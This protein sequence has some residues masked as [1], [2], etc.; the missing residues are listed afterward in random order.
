[1]EVEF[2]CRLDSGA[3]TACV[4]PR[5]YD[6]TLQPD[7][8]IRVDGGVVEQIGETYEKRPL[9][10]ATITSEKNRAALETIRRNVNTLAR[11]EG[12]VAEI[13]KTTPAIVW[14]AFGVHGIN[15]GP[16]G[17][18]YFTVGD[19]GGSAIAVTAASPEGRRAC[20][21]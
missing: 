8:A 11:G 17:K 5:S 1:M 16:D 6:Y 10:L 19:A 2:E 13:A 9:V 12:D 15:I 7:G 3:W 14:L 18:L 4:S 20:A 21:R